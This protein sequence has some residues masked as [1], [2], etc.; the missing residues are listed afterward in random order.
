MMRHYL[1]IG[2]I[3]SAAFSAAIALSPHPAHATL[4]IAATINGT[5][6]LC[7]DN[8]AACDGNLA[9]GTIDLGTQTIA[10]VTVNGSIQTS[11][12]TPGTPGPIDIL[13][14]TNLSII[15]TNAATVTGTVTVSDTSF[16]A[17]ITSIGLSGSGTWQS[18]IGSSV[19]MKWWA[20]AANAQGADTATDTPGTL[21][22]TFTNSATAISQSISH[23]ND[24]GL[25]ANSPFSMTEQAAF[26]LTAGGQLLSR[27]QNMNAVPTPEPAS[28]LLLGAGLVGMA[29]VRRRVRR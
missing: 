17:P 27:G 29:M 19:T 1:G 15:N 18:A 12:G 2:M 9:T 14:T 22:D 8:N 6:F 28:M 13:N 10:G 7:V 16:A 24:V 20:D 25:I 5:P 23:N 11:V 4:Q 26:S 21:L 3:A